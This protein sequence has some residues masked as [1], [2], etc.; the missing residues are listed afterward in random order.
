MT[1]WKAADQ[2]AVKALQQWYGASPTGLYTWD[3]PDSVVGAEANLS[4][5]EIT[6]IKQFGGLWE[7]LKDTLRWWN[8]ANAI[9]ALIDYMSVTGD[10]SYVESVVDNSFKNGPNTWRPKQGLN[11]GDIIAAA[12]KAGLQAAGNVFNPGDIFGGK[13]S[14]GAVFVN[15]IAVFN[16]NFLDDFYDDNGWWALAWIKAFDLTGDYKYITQADTIFNDMT[17]GWDGV[18]NGGIYWQR[19]Q[20]DGSGN[21][22]YK[23]AIANELFMAVAAGLSVRVDP[24]YLDWASNKE[25]SWFQNST[26]INQQS[27][28]NDSLNT[29]CQNKE[30]TDVLTYNQGVILG[31]LSDLFVATNDKKYLDAAVQIADAMIRQ[32]VKTNQPNNI[33]G[34]NQGILTE[35]ND[36]NPNAAV[37]SKQFKG[38]FI[39]NLSYLY[40][41]RP[42]A[43]F[44]AFI[45]N[46]ANSAMN[47]DMN[48]SNQFG[49]NWS[50]PFDQADFVRQTAAVDL[51]NAANVVP[52]QINYT[53]MKQFCSD[54]GVSLPARVGAILNGAGSLASLMHT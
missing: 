2:N 27:L 32:P 8:T 10:H 5:A 46:N 24:K 54:S 47:S 40:K 28:V 3:A 21:K 16:T 12:A 1:S 50:G 23:N 17:N 41:H 53:S 36:T 48:E 34:V 43:R 35:W 33:S 19:N 51:F 30:T 26:L 31:A 14:P 4:G 45:L 13:A 15:D 20:T 39:R 18:C 42:L 44:R 37:N 7:A 11:A 9:T 38:I 52:P 25:W 22:P 6:A 29:L 49:G